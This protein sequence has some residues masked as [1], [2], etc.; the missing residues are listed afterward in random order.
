[1]FHYQ[2]AYDGFDSLNE[3]RPYYKRC[4]K[5]K[6]FIL[7]NTAIET[8]KPMCCACNKLITV[9]DGNRC[10][11]H[12]KRNMIKCMHYYCAWGVTMREIYR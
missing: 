3:V 5:M 1:M 8:E 4:R 2:G 10:E 11:F 12:P 7:S 6:H 9:K